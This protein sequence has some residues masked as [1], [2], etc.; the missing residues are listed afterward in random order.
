M[1]DPRPEDF[2]D[3]DV[4]DPTDYTGPIPDD[5]PARQTPA[6]KEQERLAQEQAKEQ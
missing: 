2:E 4:L 3:D 6:Q 1:P 5:A